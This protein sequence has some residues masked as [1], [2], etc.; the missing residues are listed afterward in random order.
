MATKSLV[1]S[2]A[3]RLTG[4]TIVFDITPRVDMFG[5]GLTELCC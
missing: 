4:Q 3:K 1:E 2:A 5:G